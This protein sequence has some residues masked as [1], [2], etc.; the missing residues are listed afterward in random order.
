[1]F[2]RLGPRKQRLTTITLIKKASLTF[3][4][5]HKKKPLKKLKKTPENSMTTKHLCDD[6]ERIA[7]S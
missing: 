4:E 1:M 2:Q 3:L 5:R 7:I 6:L